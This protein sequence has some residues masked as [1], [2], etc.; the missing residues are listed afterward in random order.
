M[1]VVGGLRLLGSPG[2]ALA[3]AFGAPEQRRHAACGPA[4][5]GDG[6]GGAGWEEADTN[7][8]PAGERLPYQDLAAR[9]VYRSGALPAASLADAD[10]LFTGTMSRRSPLPRA[11][12]DGD[13]R[14]VEERLDE[15][16]YVERLDDCILGLPNCAVNTCMVEKVI[17]DGYVEVPSTPTGCAAAHGQ[18][19][20]EALS[21]DGALVKQHQLQGKFSGT[22]SLSSL[23]DGRACTTSWRVVVV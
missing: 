13:Q 18:A 2:K 9:R 15:L 1:A 11:A 5:V 14:F 17:E 4:A 3:F 16:V 23:G 21:W 7:M 12:K 6:D 22:S 19:Q 10:Y 20:V 8:S